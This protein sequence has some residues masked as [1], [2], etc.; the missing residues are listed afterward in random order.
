VQYYGGDVLD[1]SLL[2]VPQ[3]GF[4]PHDDRRVVST[5]SAIEKELISNG[6]VHRYRTD[7]VDDGVGGGEGA[8]IACSF[9]LADAYV[10]LGRFDEAEDLFDRLLAI[11]NDL[12]LLAEEYDPLRRRLTGNFPQGF[13]HI[14]LIN[15]AFNLLAARGPAHQ[16]SQKAAPAHTAGRAHEG[17]HERPYTDVLE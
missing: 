13:S 4:L 7:Q 5:V 2:L 11:R 17:T 16:R 10:M 9:W 15:T 12:G 3:V 8:F 14:G 6:F 1:A